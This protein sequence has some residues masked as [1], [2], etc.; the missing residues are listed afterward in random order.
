MEGNIITV[1]VIPLCALGL[2]LLGISLSCRANKKSDQS[3]KLSRQAEARATEINH[4]DL[5]PTIDFENGVL[6]L[7]NHG[8]GSACGL[9]GTIAV[10]DAE[11][12]IAPQDLGPG[13]S[14]T[15][16]VPT[17]A[18]ACRR[19]QRRYVAREERRIHREESD[20]P[21]DRYRIMNIEDMPGF[22]NPFEAHYNVWWD[23]SWS[24]PAG[25]SVREPNG[26]ETLVMPEVEEG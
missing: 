7:K 22:Y 25:S 20:D 17:A 11:F 1:Y 9:K 24:T 15:V 26:R 21:L 12:T 14:L 19:Y 18:E 4:V 6:M 10:Q 23:L 3:L 5:R 2:A 16:E 8:S 13:D